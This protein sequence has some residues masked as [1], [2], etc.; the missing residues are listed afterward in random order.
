MNYGQNSHFVAANEPPTIP[1][2]KFIIATKEVINKNSELQPK[3][4]KAT[5][6]ALLGPHHCTVAGK[7]LSQDRIKKNGKDF[8]NGLSTEVL[9][10]ILRRQIV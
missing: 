5:A 9:T 8:Q 4:S 7:D 6:N 3:L 1:R 2:H 10:T